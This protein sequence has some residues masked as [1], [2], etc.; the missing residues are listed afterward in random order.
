M[1]S[2]FHICVRTVLLSCLATWVTV[3]NAQHAAGQDTDNVRTDIFI[4][5]VYPHLTTYGVYSQAGGHYKAGHNECGIGAIV[6]WA[7]KLWLVNYAPHMP[8]GSEHKLFSIDP[9]LKQP[10][11]IHPESVGGTPAGRMVH[12]ESNQLLIAHYLIDSAGKVRTI[13]PQVMPMRVTAI[14]R[15]LK[16]PANMVYYI[17]MEGAIWEAN[18]HTLAVNR[19]FEKPVP[20][21]HS[22]GGYTSQGRL[23]VSNNGEL[24][25]GN[26][27]KVLVGGAAKDNEEAGVLAQWDGDKWQIVERRQFT[28][29]TG[30][31]GIF[32]NDPKDDRLWAVGWD[33]RSLRLKLLDKGEWHTYLLPKAAYCN[34]AKHGWYTEWPRIREVGNGR[35]M[36][37]MHGMFFDFPKQFSASNTRG[38]RPLASHLRYVPDFCQW[39]DRLVLATDETSIQENPLAGQP[40]SNL[41][42][43]SMDEL[44]S[45]GPRSAYGG[46]W[47]EDKVEARK[48]SDPFLIAGFD[49]RCLHLAVGARQTSNADYGMRTSDQIKIA[50][51]PESLRQ[52]VRVTIDRGDWQT[53]APGYAFEVNVPVVVYLA[54]DARGQ[55][56]LDPEWQATTL[57]VESKHAAQSLK[58]RVYQRQFN[59]GRI[60]IPGNATEHRTGS[61]G[62]PHLTFV[63]TQN[64]ADREKLAVTPVGQAKVWKQQTEQA[65]GQTEPVTFTLQIDKQG[66]GTWENYRELKLAGDGYSATMLPSDLKA[67]WIRVVTDRDC[68]ATAFF[69]LTDARYQDGQLKANRELFEGLANVAEPTT[70]VSS[71]WLYPAK[72]N[73]DLR[74]L[75]TDKDFEFTKAKF[76]FQPTV[77]KANQSQIASSN[78]KADEKLDTT[79]RLR[80]LLAVKPAFRLDEASVVIEFGSERLRLPK[81]SAEYDEPWTQGWPRCNREVESERQLANIHGTFYELPLV[82]N[83]EPPAWRLIRPVAS[84]RKRIVDFCSWNGLLVL[85]GART[86]RAD[87][88]TFVDQSKGLALWM[89]GIDDLWKLGKPIGVGGPWK[90]SSVRAGQPSDA[91]LMTGYD[92]K[93]LELSHTSKAE[94]AFQIQVDINGRGLWCN[95]ARASV[96]AESTWRH[97]FP[98][99][100]S[101]SWIRAISEQDTNATLT[102]RYE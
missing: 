93:S 59:A 75:T 2:S 86:D 48:P 26:Y 52:A 41:W 97:T 94:C 35:M 20:G 66:N 5:G 82:I 9:D 99:G 42:F 87:A 101:A 6:P 8:K 95:Y 77:V 63:Q 38:I 51:L 45:W 34:D 62:M 43:G 67:E 78:T 79:S 11:T 47:V 89:G 83:G 70:N 84:H 81:G 50:T 96:P 92:R 91:Y 56:K 3:N 22:K 72:A 90:N 98:E 61:F 25:V 68:I 33:R 65:T 24:A 15:H 18:V 44:E 76:E 16:D 40:Q 28:E 64:A 57:E 36:M 14:A 100:F 88:H 102:L 7:G 21:W 12:R 39:N 58:D 37:D 4:S 23:V 10:M 85:A 17:D 49:R 31:G 80:E 1:T 13:S 29:V 73:R 71:A 30:P 27:E 69:H 74:V 19:L 60:D 55:A 46:P 54:V 53:A 32:G